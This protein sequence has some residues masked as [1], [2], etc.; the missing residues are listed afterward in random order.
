MTTHLKVIEVHLRL[1]SLLVH[2]GNAVDNLEVLHAIYEEWSMQH[3]P[4]DLP[5]TETHRLNDNL[6]S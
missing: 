5:P 1:R 4:G 2:H 6:T 3:A